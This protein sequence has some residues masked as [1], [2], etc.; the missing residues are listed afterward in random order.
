MAFIMGLRDSLFRAFPGFLGKEP[1]IKSVQS[2]PETRA[3]ET[4]APE[5]LVALSGATFEIPK[6]EENRT[7]EDTALVDE[8]LG[9]CLVAD[10]VS[11]GRNGKVASRLAVETLRDEVRQWQAFGRGAVPAEALM[12]Q[13]M[14]RASD[15]IEGEI[16]A[17]RE[18]QGM[19][20]T[21][22]AILVTANELGEP[23]AVVG[24]VGDSRAYLYRPESNLLLPLTRDDNTIASYQD[25]GMITA[26]E[27]HAIEQSTQ[28]GRDVVLNNPE[29]SASRLYNQRREI[30][31]ALALTN[32]SV[33]PT[34]HVSRFD[35]KNGDIILTMS[36]G[37]SDVLTENQMRE[38][39]RQ[40]LSQGK[41]ISDIFQEM[42]TA[43]QLDKS[44][45]AKNDDMSIAGFEVKE[46][47]V[48]VQALADEG[49]REQALLE[50]SQQAKR[51]AK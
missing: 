41:N 8:E 17:H 38:I 49:Q 24:H 31:Q 23:Q 36:D 6:R 25:K 10:G 37:V 18:L 3:P 51:L 20:T 16:A 11:S 28:G 30:T 42:A 50:K 44:S 46:A 13:A 19:N 26:E 2:T 48:M 39:L 12:E 15:A 40:G 27:A 33:K 43:A 47:Q 32:D 5:R 1:E 7:S 9:L 34:Y 22:S 35:I 14:F 45:R 21:L 4:R 29:L